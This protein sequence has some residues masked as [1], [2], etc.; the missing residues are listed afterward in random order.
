M[1]LSAVITVTRSRRKA[2]RLDTC[3]FIPKKT[4]E[5]IPAGLWS[6]V[7]SWHEVYVLH[8]SVI[9]FMGEGVCAIPACI[10]GGI[11]ACLAAGGCLPRGVC[12]GGVSALGGVCFQDGGLE[13]PLPRKQTATVADGTHPTGMHSCYLILCQH[14][15]INPWIGPH[16]PPPIPW[17]WTIH[18]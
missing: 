9:L 18:G 8:V 16:W 3:G 5:H 10:V 2:W 15:I 11:P 17:Q 1:K 12:S 4:Q 13:I 14:Q 6:L 7:N